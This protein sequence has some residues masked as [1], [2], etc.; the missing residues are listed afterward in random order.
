MGFWSGL[1]TALKTAGSLAPLAMAPFTGGASL[2]LAPAS[3]MLGK[4]GGAVKGIS[5][6]AGPLASGIASGQQKGRE[7]TNTAAQDAALFKLKESGQN[8]N[9]LENRADLDLKRRGDTRTAQSDSYKKALNSA[10]AMNMKDVS[11]SGLDP[12]I[13]KVSFG[14]GARPSAIGQEGRD[15]AGVMNKQAMGQL[16]NPEAFAD[17]PAIER[18][19]AP[20]FKQ[21]GMLE[22][23]A[24][25][26]GM[27]ANA[28]N[29]VN[30]QNEQK[31]M[32]QKLLDAIE[33][34]SGT[35]KASAGPALGPNK[36]GVSTNAGVQPFTKPPT[37]KF[38]SNFGEV[39]DGDM[40]NR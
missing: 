16:M 35:G 25:G 33:A 34:I 27:G 15:A 18:T 14:G 39:G 36:V 1:G 17:M 7:A 20:E 38:Q 21:P 37:A 31:T 30:A 6:I 4:I 29:G 12:S 22:N 9:A 2:A 19:A 10:L 26:I 11:L 28:I 8:E 13:P 23:I 32:Q 5:E 3:G 40:S 24:G